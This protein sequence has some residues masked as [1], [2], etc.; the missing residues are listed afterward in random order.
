MG[1]GMAYG[2]YLENGRA[3]FRN[4]WVKTPKLAL[5]DSLG[6]GAFEWE[7][8]F[9]DHRNMGWERILRSPENEGVPAGVANT[10]IVWHGNQLLAMGEDAVA[11]LILDPETLE[12]TGVVNWSNRL[13]DGVT[14]RVNSEGSG[15][16]AI[17]A[18]C[19]TPATRMSRTTGLSARRRSS[20][21]PHSLRTALRTLGRSSRRP[22]SRDGRST[23][24][25]GR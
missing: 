4:R 2:L 8:G 19:C 12:T 3:H 25:P 17:P 6:R 15:S 13:G 21:W 23:L 9:P 24:T 22:C 16:R 5:E 14:P 7:G 18:T 20:P 1:D 10:N 11:P